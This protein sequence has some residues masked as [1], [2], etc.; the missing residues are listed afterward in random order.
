[1]YMYF[2]VHV[3]TWCTWCPQKPEEG[4]ES[5]KMKLEMVVSHCMSSGNPTWVLWKRNKCLNC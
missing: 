1:V 2:Y 3:C 4:I 5:L